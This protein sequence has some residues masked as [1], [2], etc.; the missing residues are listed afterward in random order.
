MPNLAEIMI[1]AGGH[2]PSLLTNKIQGG[3]GA[4]L[5]LAANVL[6]SDDKKESKK[7][8]AQKIMELLV[9]AGVGG[10]GAAAGGARWGMLGAL[11]GTALGSAAATLPNIPNKLDINDPTKRNILSMAGAGAG[12][13]LGSTLFSMASLPGTP[14][15][16]VIKGALP[17]MAHSIPAMSKSLDKISPADQKLITDQF[18][19]MTHA[20][21]ARPVSSWGANVDKMMSINSP[22]LNNAEIKLS[23]EELTRHSSSAVQKLRNNAPLHTLLPEEH[24]ALGADK[25][26][27]PELDA[28]L[29]ENGLDKSN[30]QEV[31]NAYAN[32]KRMPTKGTLRYI[33][34]SHIGSPALYDKV[35]E[36]GS[37]QNTPTKDILMSGAKDVGAGLVTGPLSGGIVG[38]KL[39]LLHKLV[40][41]QNKKKEKDLLKSA[42][43]EKIPTT[44]EEYDKTLEK[45]DS[46]RLAKELALKGGVAGGSLVA[47][48]PALFGLTSKNNKDQEQ[49]YK[50]IQLSKNKG[51]VDQSVMVPPAD[52]LL[53]GNAFY[54]PTHKKVVMPEGVS[55]GVAAH[56]LGHAEQFFKSPK[57]SKGMYYASKPGLMTGM[58]ASGF[59]ATT[60]DEKKAKR[61]SI[62]STL[63]SSPLVALEADASHRGARMLRETGTPMLKS[64]SAFK[65]VPSYAA[66]AA[67]PLV[68]YLIKKHTLGYKY[69]MEKKAEEVSTEV[70]TQVTDKV[71]LSDKFDQLI[72][73]KKDKKKDNVRINPNIIGEALE[74]GA[75][76]LANSAEHL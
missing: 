18:A 69:P 26:V 19:Y 5:G 10:A 32:F 35:M 74:Q 25:H 72:Q 11:G 67:M 39:A 71:T 41:H 36:H 4:G 40:E 56:E 14:L 15:G 63:L 60:E 16:K 2:I 75:K 34:D 13:A 3:I 47:A 54:E 28:Y 6:T 65:G 42:A 45:G 22:K 17:M 44:A 9:S 23:P 29:S 27:S 57:L 64:L 66:V 68:T 7:S 76:V 50:I 48:M 62:L 1:G 53:A 51:Y 38:A 20:T 12:T 46:S 37:I 61:Y 8:K 30:F 31:N 24:V 52:D 33:L 43:A 70:P 73:K 49:I 59:A 55:K 21:K 58:L